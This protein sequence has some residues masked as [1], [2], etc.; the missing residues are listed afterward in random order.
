M[1]LSVGLGIS[2][3]SL[4][5][6]ADQTS[7]VSRNIANAGN[8][9]ASRKAAN[10]ITAAGGGVKIASIMRVTNEALFKS[11]LS[12]T[13]AAAGQR[14]IVD[15]LDRLDQ[16]I[17]DPELDASP[18]ALI[19]KFSSALQQYADTPTNTVLART[20][21]SAAVDLTVGLN[22]AAVTVQQVRQQAD[23]DI[24]ASVDRINSLL[25]QFEALNATIVKGTRTGADVTDQLDA[26]DQV[27]ASISEEIGIR[28][29]SRA[30]GGLAIYTDS[31]AT[32]FDVKARAVTFNPTVSLAAGVTGNAV[33]VD[34]VPVVGPSATMPASSGR[35]VGL[36]AV[37]DNIAVIYQSQLDEIA[38]GLIEAFRESDQSPTPSLPD[39]P[40]LFTW[41][42]A[43]ALPPSG[44]IVSG[45]AASIRISAS[46]DPAQGGNPSLLRDGAISGNGAYTYNTTGASGFSDR[47]QQLVD[48]MLVN[49]PFDPLAQSGNSAR[50]SDFAAS[51]AAWLESARKSADAEVEYR[52]TLLERSTES[53]SKISGVNLDEE[54]T[55]LLELERTYQA[56]SKLI[57]TIDEMFNTLLAAVG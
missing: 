41:P 16:T 5:V 47:L 9:F 6:S 10:V 1:T 8:P 12:T 31:G 50:I 38:R 17:N 21:V 2:Q 40:G 46:V 54:M 11:V 4:S 15:A 25:G 34:G 57:S 51:S 42:G 39:V 28:T 27:L 33:Y 3:S 44:A 14:A 45:L 37:R 24:A 53:L 19:A 30:D 52:T 22:S 7:I 20:A 26:R 35:L 29:V 23:N 49:R 18:A 36:A 32:L 13:S 56:S 43:P 48:E 55:N